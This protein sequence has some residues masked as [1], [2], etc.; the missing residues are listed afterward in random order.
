MA[1]RT[2][3][4]SIHSALRLEASGSEIL[5][6]DSKLKRTQGRVPHGKLLIGTPTSARQQF[7]V[8]LAAG[9]AAE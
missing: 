4:E 1:L 3:Q 6:M 5:Y 2:W 7:A 9:G 8:W